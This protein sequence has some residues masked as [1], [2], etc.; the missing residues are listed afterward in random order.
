MAAPDF[1]RDYWDKQC[2][3]FR[4][5]LLLL[6]EKPSRDAIHD[7]RVAVKKMYST[8]QFICILKPQKADPGAFPNIR[9]FFRVAGINR[10]A[11]ISLSILRKTGRSAGITLPSFQYYL[12]SIRS[13]AGNN[14]KKAAEWPLENTLEILTTAF[15]EYLS[16]FSGEQLKEL[17]DEQNRT[18][19]N[20]ALGLMKDFEA[21]AH[22]IRKELKQLYYG[23]I[24]S[25][26][27]TRF[28]AKEMKLLNKTLDALGH[29]H[30]YDVF[31][32]RL[33]YFRRHY[34]AKKTEEYEQAVNLEKV[35]RLL[36]EEWLAG[37]AI[38]AR[39]LFNA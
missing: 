2:G 21:R 4:Q 12:R 11:D 38:K 14:T 15:N 22:Q 33:K 16:G 8:W 36:C 30:D 13:F 32:R 3:I 17:L 29:W 7:I 24:S 27:N 5:N 19:E 23:L 10:D 20:E 18:K 25:P 35:A 9:H 34:L 1:I 37:A 31:C 6:R 26:Q 39:R 28:D